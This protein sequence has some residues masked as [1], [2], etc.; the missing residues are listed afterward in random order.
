M[1]IRSGG[2][3]RDDRAHQAHPY[4][5][6]AY[7]TDILPPV[8]EPARRGGRNG[9]GGSGGGAIGVVKF[10]VFALVLATLV[11]VVA[12][13]ALRPVVN[14]AILELGRGQPGRPL[15]A[16]REDIVRED[17]GD[18]LTAPV[19]SDPTQVE[20]VVQDGD[21]ATTIGDAP[22][23]SRASSVTP[24]PSSSSPSSAT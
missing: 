22:R 5:P 4:D 10:L 9:R 15:D 24:A 6:D 14:N 7:A 12:L 2:R 16:V 11:L 23:D 3:P 17:L 13:T 1:T 18:S 19:S 21:T 8:V 20:F